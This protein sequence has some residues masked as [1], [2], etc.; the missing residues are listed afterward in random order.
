MAKKIKVLA[1]NIGLCGDMAKKADALREKY[2]VSTSHNQFSCICGCTSMADANRQM[3]KAGIGARFTSAYTSETGNK[4]EVNLA[5]DGGI[6]I[7]ITKSVTNRIFVTVEELKKPLEE[8]K[9]IK[10]AEAETEEKDWNS[11]EWK[12]ADIDPP[13]EKE[14][15]FVCIFGADGRK[16]MLVT[17]RRD[18]NYWDGIGRTG[19][20]IFWK[21]LPEPPEYNP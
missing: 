5:K 20:K 1:T 19:E 12:D 6:F 17:A 2:G 7:E 3:E 11:I 8:I 9:V 14:D 16:K 4:Y 15:V 21:P 13:K 18:Y 10:E